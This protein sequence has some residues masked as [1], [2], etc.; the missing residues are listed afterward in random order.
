MTHELVDGSAAGGFDAASG[1]KGGDGPLLALAEED[2]VDEVGA[3]V[4]V[5]D[6]EVGLQACVAGC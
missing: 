5:V 6:G 1:A 3:N 4:S 2:L